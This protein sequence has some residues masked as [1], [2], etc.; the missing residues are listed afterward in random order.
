ML[1]GKSSSVYNTFMR[2]HMLTHTCMHKTQHKGNYT[3][4]TVYCIHTKLDM[5]E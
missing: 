5:H 3:Q 1:R 4:H 2:T